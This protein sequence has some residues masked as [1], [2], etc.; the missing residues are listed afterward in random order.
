[1]T[2]IRIIVPTAARSVVVDFSDVPGNVLNFGAD[3]T[4]ATDT[5]AALL[6]AFDSD[7]A[8]YIPPGEYQYAATFSNTTKPKLVWCFGETGTLNGSEWANGRKNVTRLGEQVRF[9]AAANVD[10]VNVKSLMSW[11]GGQFNTTNVLQPNAN[12]SAF[13]VD[14]NWLGGQ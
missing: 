9:T 8:I 6:A 13:N 11:V 7:H 2:D 5:S 10:A 4:G 14:M 12:K 1:M 3:A